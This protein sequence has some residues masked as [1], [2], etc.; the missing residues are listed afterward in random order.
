MATH[1]IPA[2]PPDLR[3]LECKRT[4]LEILDVELTQWE[5]ATLRGELL[6]FERHYLRI[7]GSRQA[8]LD[9]IEAQ[10]WEMLSR[11]SPEDSEAIE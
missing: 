6:A 5:L 9:E 4:E 1:I 11:Y 8:E 7:V 2:V 3:E 10:V